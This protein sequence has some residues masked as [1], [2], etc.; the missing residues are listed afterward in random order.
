MRKILISVG[1]CAGALLTAWY[2]LGKTDNRSAYSKAEIQLVATVTGKAFEAP[3]SG[4]EHS[5]HYI[6]YYKIDSG[7]APAEIEDRIHMDRQGDRFTWID[8]PCYDALKTG[9]KLSV[10]YSIVEIYDVEFVARH[11]DCGGFRAF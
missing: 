5:G 11:P 7:T 9:D 1:I 2:V 3:G 4:G 6:V 8:P 10:A